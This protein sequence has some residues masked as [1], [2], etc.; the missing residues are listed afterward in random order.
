MAY[1]FPP[2]SKIFDDLEKYCDYC[3]SEGKV[4][5]EKDLYKDGAP[6]WEAYKKY[7][8][9]RRAIARNGGKPFEGRRPNPKFENNLSN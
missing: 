9:W 1:N 7:Q 4:F 5:D 6:V 2:I 8:G 3:R